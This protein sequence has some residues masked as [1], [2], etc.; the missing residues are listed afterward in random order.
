MNTLFVSDTNKGGT[1]RCRI[2]YLGKD[3]IRLSPEWKLGEDGVFAVLPA[4]WH[5]DVVVRA[6]PVD[7]LAPAGGNLPLWVDVSVKHPCR[8]LRYNDLI[9]VKTSEEVIYDEECLSVRPVETVCG[10]AYRRFC[11]GR[12]GASFIWR[13]G[14]SRSIELPKYSEDGVPSPATL[15][16]L[17]GAAEEEGLLYGPYYYTA[18]DGYLALKPFMDYILQ[19]HET[20]NIDE[21]LWADLHDEPLPFGCR[22]L[23]TSS[24]CV[25]MDE[26]GELMLHRYS[27]EGQRSKM[28]DVLQQFPSIDVNYQDEEGKTPLMHA[29]ET[30][31]ADVVEELLSYAADVH[32]A[33][34]DGETAL[35]LAERYQHESVIIVLKH[36]HV[37][38]QS[39]TDSGEKP[40]DP[41]Q[42]KSH[43]AAVHRV[44][45]SRNRE[46]PYFMLVKSK[47]YRCYTTMEGVTFDIERAYGCNICSSETLQDGGRCACHIPWSKIRDLEREFPD[48][49]WFI[50]TKVRGKRRTWRCSM[51]EFTRNATMARHNGIYIIYFD[52]QKGIAYT[53]PRGLYDLFVRFVKEPTD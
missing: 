44:T 40:F 29:C 18:A 8:I 15:L 32:T 22:L 24:F 3:R 6:F 20:L 50:D 1:Y 13:Q 33:D 25:L 30:G 4:R 21:V 36:F 34:K 35:S 27:R 45:P 10:K 9:R 11:N 12:Q 52:Y 49:D 38:P 48:A 37:W 28:S 43:Q 5:A 47:N 17:R 14:D 51:R 26:E 19:V 7:S 2:A 16:F 42:R 31:H 53:T 46:T 41:N 23:C 39:E